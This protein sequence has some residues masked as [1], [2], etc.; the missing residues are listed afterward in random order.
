MRQTS[1]E[2]FE[3]SVLKM[4]YGIRFHHFVTR[5]GRLVAT[6]AT[7]PMTLD[8]TDPQA[9]VG[10]A[11]AVCSSADSPSRARGRQI[12]LGR[13]E[14][15]KQETYPLETLKSRI[16]DRSIL[17]DF[18]PEGLARRLGYESTAALLGDLRP[19]R[20]FPTGKDGE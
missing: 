8:N 16:A 5:G 13:L 11:C 1:R 17:A 18:V 10:V 20:T 4:L 19:R 9:P 15:G 3:P 12:A 14:V 2:K 7:E 6:L